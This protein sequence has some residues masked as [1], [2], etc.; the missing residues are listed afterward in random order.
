[1]SGVQFPDLPE[2]FFWRVSPVYH[3]FSGKYAGVRLGLMHRRRRWWGGAAET[4]IAS[5]TYA[6]S[7]RRE[8]LVEEARKILAR[9]ERDRDEYRMVGD[10]PPKKFENEEDTHEG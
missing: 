8:A 5:G 1:M 6:L 9:L 4:E 7:A 3:V 2:G 10:Y